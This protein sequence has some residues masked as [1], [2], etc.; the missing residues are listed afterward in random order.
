MAS[1]SDIRGMTIPNFYSGLVLLSFAVAFIALSIGG[2]GQVFG[3]LWSHVASGGIFFV[4]T[5]IMFAVGALGAADSKLGAVYALW[6]SLGNMPVYLF[7]MA[8]VGGILGVCSLLIKRFKPFKN[9]P[10]GS[11]I[12]LVQGGASKV[13]YGVAIAFGMFIAFCYAGYF[14]PA[15]LST[16]LS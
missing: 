13:P 10:E 14:S 4:V 7:F 16:F 15:L 2:Q 12:D 1:V 11:W 3:P 8:L 9:A 6:F 5:F